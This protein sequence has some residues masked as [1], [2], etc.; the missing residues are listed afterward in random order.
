MGFKLQLELSAQFAIKAMWVSLILGPTFWLIASLVQWS[1]MNKSEVAA[2]VQ[3]VGSVA[4]IFAAVW[5]A[6]RDSRIRAGAEKK[7]KKDAAERSLA[8]AKDA[9]TRVRAAISGAKTLVVTDKFVETITQDLEQSQQH[10]KDVLSIQGVDSAIFNQ[11]FLINLSVERVPGSLYLFVSGDD[12]CEK[13]LAEIDAAV[14][15]LEMIK[16]SSQ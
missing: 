2:W 6:R 4:A 10:M 12:Y 3:A 16:N 5:I 11:I 15:A 13:L 7:A 1:G 14:V 9:R 8:V